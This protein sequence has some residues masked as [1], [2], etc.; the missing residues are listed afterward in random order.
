V[1]TRFDRLR[2][3]G[4]V[5]AS[6]TLAAVLVGCGSPTR[7]G[8]SASAARPVSPSNDALVSYY[9][10]PITLVLSLG[11]TTGAA[12]AGAVVEV[13]TDPGFA[14]IVTTAPAIAGARGEAA[15]AVDHL[16]PSTTYYWRV[17]T[18]VGT[19]SALEST[20]ARFHTGPL[21]EMHPPTAVEPLADSFPHKRP[22][23]VVTDAPTLGPSVGL[24]YHFDVATDSAFAHIVAAGTVPEGASST[25][26]TPHVD[27]T[28]GDTYYWRAQAF[29]P[30]SGA[31]SGYSSPQVFTIVFPEDGT[32][33]YTLT[34]QAPTSCQ[35]H[36]AASG[37]CGSAGILWDQSQFSLDGVLTFS[38]DAMRFD[39]PETTAIF[40]PGENPPGTSMH[41]TH[42]RITGRILGY[43]TNN[44][45]LMPKYS[46]FGNLDFNAMVV[47]TS[48][49][50]GRFNG[51]FDGRV[52][53][54]RQGFPCDAE[55]ACS[56]SAFT[57]I[58]SPRR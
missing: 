23:F 13:G 41:R 4:F 55:A 12:P 56:S 29:D 54:V 52:A 7:P 43:T 18:S 49:N 20:A 11:V 1:R 44:P 21:L 57:W 15:A 48:D 16:S 33:P 42:N 50:H 27:L 38:D 34:V 39:R 3:A 35:T 37:G 30:A 51:T 45:L 6:A 31:V 24:S 22:T 53:L 17:K 8:V 9:S 10:Q 25:S 58:L 19:H 47:G 2:V 36:F 14:T 28:P 40:Y 26:F 46:S 5:T 32:Y